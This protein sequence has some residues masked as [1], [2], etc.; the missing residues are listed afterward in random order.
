TRALPSFKTRCDA[1]LQFNDAFMAQVDLIFFDEPIAAASATDEDVPGRTRRNRVRV[2]S[3]VEN[4]HRYPG[5]SAANTLANHPAIALPGISAPGDPEIVV[6][7]LRNAAC[8][9]GI[10][11]G[12]LVIIHRRPGV[13]PVR[14]PPH[15]PMRGSRALIR[16]TGAPHDIDAR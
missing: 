11:C 5:P 12:E 10:G 4:I 14:A 15:D 9:T 1:L 3:G 2:N 8:L 7:V 6:H 13:A 16:C